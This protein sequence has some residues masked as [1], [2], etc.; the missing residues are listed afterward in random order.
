MNS[1]MRLPHHFISIERNAQ[2]QLDPSTLLED[3]KV[4]RDRCWTAY[5]SLDRNDHRRNEFY[6]DYLTA[7][8]EIRFV[9]RS[10][11]HLRRNPET[12]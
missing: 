3:A 12:V 8:T 2:M 5:V 10:I 9:R 1:S 6:A 7:E 4:K 11:R